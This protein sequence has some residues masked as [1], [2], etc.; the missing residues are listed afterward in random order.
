MARFG[1]TT[2]LLAALLA[3][4]DDVPTPV[5]AGSDAG[6]EGPTETNC[7]DRA[8]DD[9]DDLV[10]CADPDCAVDAACRPKP[11]KPCSR[12]AD[13]GNIVDELVTKCCLAK[14]PVSDEPPG[15]LRCFAPG[16]TEYDGDAIDSNLLFALVFDNSFAQSPSKPKTAVVRFIFPEKLDGTPLSC[17]EVLAL[18]GATQETRS[19]LDQDARINQV[20][21][22]LYV[23]TWGG[24]NT[25]F[26]N[27]IATVPRGREFILYGEA[28]YGERDLNNP[29]GNRAA[30]FCR[31]GVTVDESSVGQ[32]F[33]L[34]FKPNT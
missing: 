20:F 27:I 4:G 12:Q 18:N 33:E 9:G 30:T 5:D 34:S 14:S 16:E 2:L 24:S 29:T 28:W 21:R 15:A 31:E 1:L 11:P 3:C 13:C 26:R 23:L 6:G 17:A 10:D 22:S 25:V 32:H 7:V 19:R 8:D